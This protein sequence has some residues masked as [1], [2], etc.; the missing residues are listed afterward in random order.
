M[1]ASWSASLPPKPQRTDEQ[2]PSPSPHIPAA[3]LRSSVTPT[4]ESTAGAGLL[5]GTHPGLRLA[6]PGLREPTEFRTDPRGAQQGRKAG[7]VRKPLPPW[8]W[9]SGGGGPGHPDGPG[10]MPFVHR[11]SQ[12]RAPCAVRWGQSQAANGASGMWG[13]HHAALPGASGTSQ[14]RGKPNK[15]KG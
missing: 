7:L 4:A 14:S 2:G 15:W 9:G 1:S 8:P 6:A 10:A 3:A 5:W 13:D 12:I 11:R